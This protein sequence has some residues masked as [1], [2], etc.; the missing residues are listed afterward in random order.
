MTTASSGSSNDAPVRL[1]DRLTLGQKQV[2][3]AWTFLAVPIAFYA[4]IR[5]YPTISAFWLSFTDW[6]LLRPASFI[7]IENYARLI[8]DPLF[9][10]TFKNTLDR[11]STR[12]NSSH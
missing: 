2:V 7:G 3:W 5:F 11:K 10:K 12:L 4:V 9:W 1:C 6:N 8:A